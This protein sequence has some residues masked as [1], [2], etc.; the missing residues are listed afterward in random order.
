M[1]FDNLN[2]NP[3]K[4][5]GGEENFFEEPW[6][7]RTGDAWKDFFNKGWR[8][9]DTYLNPGGVIANP[10]QQITDPGNFFD[11][12]F[13]SNAIKGD[14]SDRTIASALVAALAYFGGGALIGKGGASAGGTGA[15]SM[16]SAGAGAAAGGGSA[17]G[18]F[19]KP[20]AQNVATGTAMN[21]I[22]PPQT[23]IGQAPQQQ[24]MESIQPRARS[25]GIGQSP[26]EILLASLQQNAR[27]RRSV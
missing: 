15:S 12:E 14:F 24:M 2:F 20:V 11:Q 3:R 27:N 21:A 7:D 10:A 8:R 5:M 9:S 16:G 13:F 22:N 4:G 23:Q 19:I 17:I 6:S 1:I 18:N 25:T 26:A